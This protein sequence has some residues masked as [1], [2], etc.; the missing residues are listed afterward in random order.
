MLKTQSP[1]RSTF[2][3]Q[4]LR[5]EILEGLDERLIWQHITKAQT[6]IKGENQLAQYVAQLELTECARILAATSQ[7]G[8]PFLAA[9]RDEC[10]VGPDEKRSF[11]KMIKAW[12]LE[13]L[14]G[15]EGG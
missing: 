7:E 14:S 6:I 10:Q 4:T 12:T 15:V 5:K 13:V 11:E 2:T 3:A 1:L 9:R 8:L